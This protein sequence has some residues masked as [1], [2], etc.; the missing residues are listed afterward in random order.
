MRP[1]STLF[2][3]A[4]LPGAAAG[5]SSPLLGRAHKIYPNLLQQAVGHDETDC[6]YPLG[7]QTRSPPPILPCHHPAQNHVRQQ[8]LWLSDTDRPHQAGS[9]P[10]YSPS[11]GGHEILPCYLPACQV[12]SSSCL[13]TEGR[14]CASTTTASCAC[15]WLTSLLLCT[16]TLVWTITRL[17][18]LRVPDN[19]CWLGPCRLSLFL[20]YHH[21]PPARIL[22]SHSGWTPPLSLP[23]T[24]QASPLGTLQVFW[25]RHYSARWT[26]RYTTTTS[27]S[28][29]MDHTP[30]HSP[31]QRQP[32][33]SLPTPSAGHGGSHRRQT[34]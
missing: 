27:S 1:G 30:H 12:A 9:S 23:C 20:T 31:P 32:S 11:W 7:R 15:S 26:G 28:S 14:F 21:N 22:L 5:R 18:G 34:S 33:M 8:H 2:Q 29:P 16:A 25:R 17:F 24:F 6:R 3:N 13:P 4:H 19:H 10:E